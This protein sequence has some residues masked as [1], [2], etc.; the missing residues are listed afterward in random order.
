MRSVYFCP[1]SFLSFVTSSPQALIPFYPVLYL[2][3]LTH[4]TLITLPTRKCVSIGLVKITCILP[5]PFVRRVRKRTC[6][7]QPCSFGSLQP[8]QISPIWNLFKD[9]LRRS[10]LRI[11]NTFIFDN[12]NLIPPRILIRS[13]ENS[14]WAAPAVDST[15]PP[16]QTT[17]PL[18]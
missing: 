9:I 7:D 16:S 3:Q 4:I 15:S 17:H 11:L 14:Q 2:F 10:P 1:F 13:T 12:T 8:S 5:L 18:I 6:T